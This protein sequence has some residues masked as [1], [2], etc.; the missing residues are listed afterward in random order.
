LFNKYLQ[1]AFYSPRFVPNQHSTGSHIDR[2][3]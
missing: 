3:F 2:L 1:L